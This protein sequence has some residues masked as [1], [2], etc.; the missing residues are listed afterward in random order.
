MKRRLCSIIF[1][2]LLSFTLL[3]GQVSI[4]KDRRYSPT[5]EESAFL[6]SVQFYAFKFFINEANFKNG[7]VKD[8]S[9]ATSPASIAGTGFAIP[10]WALGAERGWMSRD[11]AA[12]ITLN[13]FRFL[14][15]SEQSLDDSATGYQ[16]FYYHFLDMKTGKRFWNCELSSIDTGWLLAGILFAKQFYAADNQTE[17]EIREAAVKLTNRINWSFFEMKSDG[18]FNNTISL[19]WDKKNGF[20]SLGWW[21]YTEALFL[22]VVSAGAGMENAEQRYA[23]WLQTYQWRE[24][25][26]KESG[27]VVFPALF[28][29]QF[30]LLWIDFRNI[31]DS[32]MREK[33]IDYF[34][35]SRRATYVQRKYAIDNP[36]RWAGY[37]SLTWGLSACDGPDPKY[38]FDGK[39]FF[40]YSA[41]GTSG[42]DSTFDD[43]TVAPYASACS[44]PFAPE[45]C[46][47][48]LYSIYKN[49][50]E[51]GVWGKYGF[52]DSFNPTLNW[53]DADVLGLDSGPMVLMIENYRSGFVW[54]YLMREEIIQN[55]LKRLGFAANK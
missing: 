14:L 38:N 47:P 32:Y 20:N 12:Q 13:L 2:A 41:R 28:I 36:N 45:I 25:Y 10:I 33:K 18:F 51:K 49:Y 35:N 44:I 19:G 53:Y 6:D 40:G 5:K 55:G 29:H 1:F 3:N 31:S 52:V 15:N 34:E 24:P 42:P 4:E 16:G 7:L 48:T 46:I 27:H 30:S 17:N 22:Q 37:D 54:K 8:R 9:T 26:G 50:G 23:K 43:G 39:K 11:S 21:G